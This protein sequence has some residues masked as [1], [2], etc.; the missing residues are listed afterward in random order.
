MT[1]NSENNDQNIKAQSVKT[2]GTYGIIG[3]EFGI[4]TV[5]GFLLGRWLDGIFNTK[6]ALTIFLTFC[7]IAAA[8]LD[9]I[10]KVKKA[11]KELSN[12]SNEPESN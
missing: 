2:L 6:P 7:G 12:N 11:N 10:K 4:A 5:V 3:L 8:T 9:F 1:E